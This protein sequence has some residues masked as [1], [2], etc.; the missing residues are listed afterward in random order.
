M[1]LFKTISL[2]HIL[3]SFECYAQKETHIDLHIQILADTATINILPTVIANNTDTIELHKHFNYFELKYSGEYNPDRKVSLE[4]Q[5]PH[6]PK[7]NLDSIN[8][9]INN[10]FKLL[11]TSEYF[12][13]T[14]GIKTSLNYQKKYLVIKFE[15]NSDTDSLLSLIY[16]MYQLEVAV[17]FRDSI[18][19]KKA[20]KNLTYSK[21]GYGGI[22]DILSYTFWLKKEGNTIFYNS[23]SIYSVIRN[24]P[25]ISFLGVPQSFSENLINGFIIHLKKGI[26]SKEIETLVSKYSLKKDKYYNTYLQYSSDEHHFRTD[27][28]LPDN[29]LMIDLMKESI[30]KTA[31]IKEISYDLY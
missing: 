6:Y 9:S 27:N 4:I 15:G 19:T 21:D 23:D 7:L 17:D 25:Q 18:R 2:I 29:K 16:D 12:Y 22:E 3:F 1:N 26:D 8:L 31:L 28:L 5:H 11:N 13:V 20:D 14:N 24:S 30:V 10:R